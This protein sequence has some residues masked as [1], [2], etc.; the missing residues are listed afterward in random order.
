MEQRHEASPFLSLQ[1]DFF[2]LGS[3]KEGNT[4]RCADAGNVLYSSFTAPLLSPKAPKEGEYFL[5]D[6]FFKPK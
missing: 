6:W 3:C 2:R 1:A 5:S 4:Q